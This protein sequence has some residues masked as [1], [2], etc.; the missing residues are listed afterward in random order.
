MTKKQIATFLAPQ[1]GLTT[2]GNHAYG[3][4]GVLDIGGAETDMLN[5]TTGKFYLVGTIQFNAM[6]IS[7]ES[8]RYQV[9]LNGIVIQGYMDKDGANDVPQPPTSFI[10]IIV[11]PNTQIKATAQNVSDSATRN[12]VCNIAGRIY[13]A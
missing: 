11:P 2:L 5:F 13:D 6:E 7:G 4:S 12:Q 8:F 1:L 10:N 9:Y 3:Y